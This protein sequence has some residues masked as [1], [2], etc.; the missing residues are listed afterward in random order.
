[1]ND[2]GRNDRMIFLAGLLAA[3]VAAFL[4]FTV[5]LWCFL[6]VKAIEDLTDQ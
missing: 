3:M 6:L 2:R 5:V 4:F 1:M